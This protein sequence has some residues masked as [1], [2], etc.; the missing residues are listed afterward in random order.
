MKKNQKQQPLSKKQRKKLERSGATIKTREP[1]AKM[2]REKKWL[3][4]L[5][6][7][8]CVMAIACASFGGILLARVITDALHDPYA[9]AFE[10]IKL[11]KHIDTS[12]IDEKFYTANIFDFSAIEKNYVPMTLADMDDY[13]EG[14]RV[15]YR[16]LNKEMQRDRVIGLGDTVAAYVTD[17]FKGGS[18][19][20]SEDEKANRLTVPSKMEELFGSYTGYI[21]FV[22]GAELFGKDFDD[23]LIEAGKKERAERVPSEKKEI[24]I[25]PSWQED[26]LLDSCIDTLLERLYCEDYHITV[27]PHPEYVKRYG[28]KMQAIVDRYADKVGDKLSFELDFSKNKSV[29]SSDLLITDWSGIALEYCFATKRPAMF[30]NT[31]IKCLNPNWEKINCTP[32]EI[33]LRDQVGISVNMMVAIQTALGMVTFAPERHR[34]LTQSEKPF[35]GR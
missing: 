16:T 29:Y 3:I 23:K 2:P 11:N 19:L 13:I 31:K 9:S 28:P 18:P 33:A 7:A 30:V 20:T 17:I 27:R 8:V 34:P 10:E 5:V 22:V 6:A 25:A 1:R 15:N 26:N 32:A 35:S 12:A 14:V 24:L 4:S 21:T